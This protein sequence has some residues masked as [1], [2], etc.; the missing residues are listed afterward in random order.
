MSSEKDV[1]ETPR[2]LFDKLNRQYSFDLDA[3]STASNS[4]CSDF[5][6]E[7]GFYRNGLWEKDPGGQTG[8]N[9]LT[10]SWVGRRVWCNPPFSELPAW[11]KKAWSSQA[12]TVVML[13]PSWTE[14]GWWQ[15]LVEPHRDQD[16][17]AYADWDLPN[18]W[19]EFHV[20]FLAGRTKFTVNGGQPIRNAK[21][22]I[23]TPSWGCALL[24]WS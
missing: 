15:E 1:R 7:S 13:V 20:R 5:F 19:R 6:T 10:G 8:T 16:C 3:A 2:A 14:R 21:G 12:E 17:G 22:Q 24:I 11:V 4:L 9:G 18:G 23:G